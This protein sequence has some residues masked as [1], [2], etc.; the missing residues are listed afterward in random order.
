MNGKFMK[1][2][3]HVSTKLSATVIGVDTAEDGLSESSLAYPV[4]SAALETFAPN[5]ST[6]ISTPL[7]SL[8]VGA[9]ATTD[10]NQSRHDRIMAAMSP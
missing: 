6:G 5:A 2:F 7:L 1:L 4:K 8:T 3:K 10:G 9:S